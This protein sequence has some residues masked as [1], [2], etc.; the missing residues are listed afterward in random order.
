MEAGGMGTKASDLLPLREADYNVTP[1][2]YDTLSQRQARLLAL[3]SLPQGATQ[4][5]IGGALSALLGS[6]FIKL[7]RVAAS[8]A[9]S[10]LPTSNFQPAGKVP[11]FLALSY[12][13]A[14][15]G[16]QWV[17]Y[18]NLD[19]TIPNA[20]LLNLGDVVTVGGENNWQAEVVTVTG[21][22]TTSAGLNQFQATFTNSHD[23][24]ATVTT[25]NFPQWL[26][27]Q[28]F[29][30]VEVT[31]AVATNP[32]L[33]Q[34]IDTLMAKLVRGVVQWA[35]VTVNGSYLTQFLIGTTPL[36]TGVVGTV[37]P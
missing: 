36:G 7:R 5:N 6:G 8:E 29:L 18:Q 1:G 15:T 25:M 16:P 10:S 13:I 2:P 23:A 32:V 28:A 12:P 4:A 17:T 11:K 33:R 24:G 27:T 22:R 37:T 9:L 19:S 20:I 26:S 31:S 21:L 14:V 34:Q 3:R 35:T 30:Y